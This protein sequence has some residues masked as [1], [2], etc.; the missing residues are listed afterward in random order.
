MSWN[1]RLMRHKEDGEEYLEMHECYYN[2]AGQ[3][4]RWTTNSVTPGSETVKGVNWNLNR[5]RE[6]VKKPVLEYDMQ[7]EGEDDP[8][9]R[10]ITAKG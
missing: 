5:M 9:M 3:I 4:T 6:A 1:H 7:P 8:P 10:H 2:K